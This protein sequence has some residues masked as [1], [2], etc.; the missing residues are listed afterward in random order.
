MIAVQP[1]HGIEPVSDIRPTVRF[2]CD[3]VLV[4]GY[5]F[6]QLP[7]A[8]FRYDAVLYRIKL[9]LGNE[10]PVVCL[11]EN[12]IVRQTLLTKPDHVFIQLCQRYYVCVDILNQRLILLGF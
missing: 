4:E 10:M 12:G 8:F 6:L 3:V 1:S 11:F 5:D 2:F 9:N 7:L